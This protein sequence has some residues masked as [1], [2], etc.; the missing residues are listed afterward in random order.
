MKQATLI[1]F[2]IHFS[3]VV[4]FAVLSW[5]FSNDLPQTQKIK[6]EIKEVV[7]E[8]PL[9]AVKAPEIE[10]QRPPPTPAKAPP[11][12]VFGLNK[13]T[14][15][16]GT[17]ATVAIKAGNTVAK[18]IDQEKINPED[19]EALPIPTDEYLVTQMPILKSEVRIP[20]PAEARKKNIEG[21]VIMD[22]LI[23]EKGKVRSTTLVQG[24]GYGLNEAALRA[25][26]QFEFTPA[27]V[28][29]KPVAVKIRYSYRFILN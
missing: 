3:I 22:I 6:V 28:D 17:T 24:P 7:K 8:Q 15:E 19:A 9:Q 10:L 27:V 18:D 14:L 16:G 21:A 13:N 5:M 2:L 1:S 11:K 12:K 20:Y 25:I 4:F 26:S 29:K 23:D